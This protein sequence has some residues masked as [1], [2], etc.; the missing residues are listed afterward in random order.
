MTTHTAGEWVVGVNSDYIFCK[1]GPL[2]ARCF[3]EPQKPFLN[4]CNFVKKKEARA[5]ARLIAAAP[6]LLE[7]LKYFMEKV[8]PEDY[9]SD[10]MIAF[11]HKAQLAIQKA[12]GRS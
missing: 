9:L 3:A 1:D 4:E 8:A 6:E 5:N 12:E 7:A 10:Y 2:V 11:S